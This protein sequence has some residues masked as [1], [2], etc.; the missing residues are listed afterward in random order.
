VK[1]FATAIVGTLLFG[2]F[3]GAATEIIQRD[4]QWFE[5][6]TPQQCVWVADPCFWPDAVNRAYQKQYEDYAEN[7]RTMIRCAGPPSD[8]DVRKSKNQV[9]CRE[10]KCVIDMLE[11]E[12]TP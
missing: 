5:C 7:Q 12:A 9:V 10:R 3:P 4:E 6:D 1:C 8:N 11:C 2:S